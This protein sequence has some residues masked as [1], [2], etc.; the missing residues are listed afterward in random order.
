MIKFDT[1]TAFI[2]SHVKASGFTSG[3]IIS[4]EGYTNTGDK[5]ASRWRALGTVGAASVTP[6]TNN[7]PNLSDASGN[8]FALV[9]EGVV[10]LNALGGTTAAYIN[11]AVTAGLVYSQGLTSDVSDDI[12][13]HSTVL[14]MTNDA[15][16]AAGNAIKTKEYSTGNGGG[17]TYDVVLTSSVTP[18]GFNIIIGVSDPLISFVLRVDIRNIYVAQFGPTLD[19][20]TDNTAI[21]QL[22]CDLIG[23]DGGV[24][25][26]PFGSVFSLFSL[27]IKNRTTLFYREDDNSDK[28][29]IVNGS[30]E[31]VEFLNNGNAAGAVNEDKIA[32][33]FHPAHILNAIPS[34]A[35]TNR[36]VG[37]DLGNPRSSYLHQVDGRD[38]FQHGVNE[39]GHWV[40]NKFETRSTLSGPT[41]ALFTPSALTVGDTVTGDT[42]GAVGVYLSD[43]ASDL[44]VSL[45]T[46]NFVDGESLTSGAN[47][48]NVD[49][50]AAPVNAIYSKVFAM[51]MKNNAQGMGFNVQ[52][53]DIISNHVIGGTVTIGMQTAGGASEIGSLK[54]QDLV[55]TPNNGIEVRPK[56][57]ST[58]EIEIL[59]QLGTLQALFDFLTSARFK[60]DIV[61]TNDTT[62]QRFTYAEAGYDPLTDTPA[63]SP[64][65]PFDS[66]GSGSP[67]GSLSAPTGSTYRRTDGGAGTSFYVKESGAG[68]TGWA[69]K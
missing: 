6:L 23:S 57:G 58:T 42:S 62:A 22:A 12:K 8:E 55:T 29:D 18:N 52:P 11:I 47:S 7:S 44:V 26:I 31:L 9:G 3:E 20:A 1:A 34:Q 63:I 27:T 67:E 40:M 59:N 37:Q 35:P 15:S 49:T 65:N 36:G 64:T 30:N 39:D 66:S 17:G 48:S 60:I 4:F 61:R 45:R 69:A 13:N 5:G 41:G 68:N 32:S 46:G 53:D 33:G 19:S 28:A 54:V 50:N 21:V 10:D 51:V 24:I 14:T 2:A 16:L 56:N 38:Y 43:G 25:H